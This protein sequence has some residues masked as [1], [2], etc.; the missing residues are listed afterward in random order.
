MPDDG[1]TTLHVGVPVSWWIN[2]VDDLCLVDIGHRTPDRQQ[3]LWLGLGVHLC[4]EAQAV[5][6]R[7]RH[8]ANIVGTGQRTTLFRRV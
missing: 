2:D 7:I 5:I 8:R 6:E 3:G 4:R 1:G